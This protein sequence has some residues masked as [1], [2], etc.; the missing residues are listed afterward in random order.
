MSSPMNQSQVKNDINVHYFSRKT[1]TT[2][3]PCTVWFLFGFVMFFRFVENCFLECRLKRCLVLDVMLIFMKHA[4]QEAH[5]LLIVQEKVHRQVN[6]HYF[7]RSINFILQVVLQIQNVVSVRKVSQEYTK[8]VWNVV[9]A[10]LI[11]IQSVKLKLK[12]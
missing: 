5:I 8:R 12:Q 1:F 7:S 3:T 11:F 2:P 9:A 6:V 10:S 4:Y